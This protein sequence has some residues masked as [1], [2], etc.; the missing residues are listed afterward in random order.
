[1]CKR[2]Y[3]RLIDAHQWFDIFGTDNTNWRALW[4][5]VDE[6]TCEILDL[7]ISFSVM[8]CLTERNRPQ[9]SFLFHR[10]EHSVL[11]TS[12]L[13][14]FDLRRLVKRRKSKRTAEVARR[15]LNKSMRTR[16]L[17]DIK[18]YWMENHFCSQKK[19]HQF[20]EYNSPYSLDFSSVMKPVL[21]FNTLN[22]CANGHSSHAEMRCEV[23]EKNANKLKRNLPKTPEQ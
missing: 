16:E 4:I 6:T 13:E 17:S 21:D 22:Q 14:S 5:Y 8:G 2:M 1:M 10:M 18:H 9:P 7:Y 15:P 3:L 23:P 19:L 12:W 20:V 11:R